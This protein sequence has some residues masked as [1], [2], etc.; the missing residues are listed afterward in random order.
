MQA[1]AKGRW[2]APFE[3]TVTVLELIGSEQPRFVEFQA[4]VLGNSPLSFVLQKLAQEIE[5]PVEEAAQ[6]ISRACRDL[7]RLEKQRG[8]WRDPA[9]VLGG[10]TN[11]A[12]LCHVCRARLSRI[13]KA[14]RRQR[15]MSIQRRIEAAYR[16]GRTRAWIK[17][18]IGPL[19]GK[20]GE[21]RADAR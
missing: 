8:R 18:F 19:P 4:H 10:T 15:L 5:V 1:K 2:E 20:S 13:S 16:L 21:A 9:E 17:D 12:A 11:L 7:D 14:S 6:A 3:A